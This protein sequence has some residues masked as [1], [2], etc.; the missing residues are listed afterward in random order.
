MPPKAKR[1]GA[2]TT[3]AVLLFVYAGL[4]MPCGCW[5]VAVSFIPHGGHGP[6]I[7]GKTPGFTEELFT[8]HGLYLLLGIVMVWAG[9]G[10][11]RLKPSARQAAYWATTGHLFIVMVH[12]VYWLNVLFPTFRSFGMTSTEDEL[13]TFMIWSTIVSLALALSIISLLSLKKARAAFAIP[14]SVSLQRD[15]FR[16][17]LETGGDDSGPAKRPKNWHDPGITER[18]DAT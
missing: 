3:A 4:C 18:P 6:N 17:R 13:W 10:V 12:N 2:V 16:S 1:P 7:A 11:L 5:G 14:S 9:A 8:V 15:D